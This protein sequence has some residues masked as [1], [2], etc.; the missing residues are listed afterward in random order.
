L[1]GRSL[2]VVTGPGR[3][4]TSAVARVLHESGLRMG[5]EFSPPSEYNPVGFYEDMP[6]RELNEQIMADCGMDGLD[7]W[8]EREDVRR[9][10]EPYAS[11]MAALAATGVDGWKDPRFCITLEAWLPH[12]AASP[13]VV[14][15]LRSPEAFIH[16]VV[17]IFGLRPRDTLERWW[18]NHLRRAL[19]VV[20]EYHL[21]AT[22][23]VYED[24]VARPE[25]TVDRLASFVGQPL[26]ARFIEPALRQ[27]D[28]PVPERHRSLY[29]EVR[30]LS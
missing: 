29:E 24:L 9:A 26:D 20:R 6:V 22:S 14:V 5:T 15:C 7:R 8:P 21:P 12:L 18:A 16:S 1:E 19:D 23:V 11:A 30:A 25:A 4:G 28:Q 3:S 13:C 10:A 2:I 27:F 17:S